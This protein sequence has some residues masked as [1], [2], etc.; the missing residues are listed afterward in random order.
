M[1]RLGACLSGGLKPVR[2]EF[3]THHVVPHSTALCASLTA[4]LLLMFSNLHRPTCGLTGPS[5]MTGSAARGGDASK[6]GVGRRFGSSRAA[7]VLP[8][9][10]VD[11]ADLLNER[12]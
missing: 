4:L 1:S 5:Y 10:Y 8:G 3:Q 12:G 9:A 2:D 11:P 6:K 7:P